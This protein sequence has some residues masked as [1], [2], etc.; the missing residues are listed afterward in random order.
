MPTSYKILAPSEYIDL[1][2]GEIT[3]YVQRI[4]PGKEAWFQ[5]STG[6][7]TPHL[8]P[9]GGYVGQHNGGGKLTNTSPD[10]IK[11]KAF[12]SSNP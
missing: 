9:G 2:Q 1:P 7:Q 6:Y 3:V 10:N 12:Y 11:I 4:D 5:Y 8:I